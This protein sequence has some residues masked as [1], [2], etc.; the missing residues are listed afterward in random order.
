MQTVGAPEPRDG[1]RVGMH[2]TSMY[3]L[4]IKK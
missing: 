2:Y 3:N 4:C 1:R